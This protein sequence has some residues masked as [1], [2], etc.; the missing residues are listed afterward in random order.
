MIFTHTFSGQPLAAFFASKQKKSALGGRFY[1]Q[2]G[3]L[4]LFFVLMMMPGTDGRVD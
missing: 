1:G 2:A 4:S 3:L